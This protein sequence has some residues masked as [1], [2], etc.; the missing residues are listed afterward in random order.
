MGLDG[1]AIVGFVLS[2]G[3]GMRG[4]RNADGGGFF[5]LLTSRVAALDE[6][7]RAALAS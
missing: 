1:R 4:R 6:R 5:C 2:N 3:C 7:H